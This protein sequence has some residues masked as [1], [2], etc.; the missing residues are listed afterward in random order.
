M[1][2][3]FAI[4]GAGING[5]MAANELARAGHQVALFERTKEIGGA[6]RKSTVQI[7]GEMREYPLGATVFGHMRRFLFE[8][9]GLDRRV[10]IGA[11][12]HPG[13]YQ[14]LSDTHPIHPFDSDGLA[15]MCEVW[16]ETGDVDGFNDGLGS[17]V[18]FLGRCYDQAQVPTLEMARTELGAA[19]VASFITGDAKSLM[20]AYLTSE[21]AKV[22]FAKGV[23]ESG[24]VG[25]TEPWSALNLALAD[26]GNVLGDGRWG[27]V[28]GGIWQ[29]TNALA[30]INRE[31]GVEIGVD[32]HI[33][34]VD[35][36]KSRLYYIE[37]ENGDLSDDEC[38]FDF[39]HI[40]FATDPLTAA[41]MVDRDLEQRMKQ[42]RWLGTSGKLI[43]LFREQVC[44]KNDRG[45]PG[46]DSAQKFLIEAES[47]EEL[48][49][50]SQAVSQGLTDFYPGHY[51]IYCHGAGNR[52]LGQNDGGDAVMVFFKH[53]S[54]RVEGSSGPTGP[55][56]THGTD[57][58]RQ[59]VTKTLLSR[60]ANPEA[61]A[62]TR[63]LTPKD[64]TQE[65]FFP[66]G[67][68]EHAMNCEGQTFFSRTYSAEPG[69]AFYR[70][71][72]HENAWYCGAGS[73]PDGSVAGTNG[74][75]C[76]QEIL[77]S[78]KL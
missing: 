17:V 48:N 41:R 20:D 45:R 35:M 6:A 66:R 59:T 19:Q 38:D 62:W 3:R 67:N 32:R 33:Y 60:I 30:A 65:F 75:M 7:D 73:F 18:Q 54:D 28:K 52:L 43:A 76:S 14:F 39:D 57:I 5:L 78:L 55:T 46:Y 64:L 23:V 1:R 58:I 77:R 53:L 11:S 22:V 4:I 27:Y 51:E 71:G 47:I 21:K 63:L 13:E 56:Y 74:Y 12:P 42:K 25:L 50:G 70:F 2:K 68:I 24:P 37:R 26:T 29:I 8:R 69:K 16:G 44:W 9:T 34:G 10:T 61:L 31:L 36:K 40:I 49:R 15:E 72:T